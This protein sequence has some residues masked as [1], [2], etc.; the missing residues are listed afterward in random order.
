MINGNSQA[1]HSRNFLERSNFSNTRILGRS[2]TWR[3]VTLCHG[4][5]LLRVL[6]VTT[7]YYPVL[8]GTTGK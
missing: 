6:P 5:P 8:Q 1:V 4:I 2:V 3:D 7:R